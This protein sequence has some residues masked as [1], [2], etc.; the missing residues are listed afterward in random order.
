MGLTWNWGLWA[1]NKGTHAR[2]CGCIICELFSFVLIYQTWHWCHVSGTLFQHPW[3]YVEFWMESSVDGT[4]WSILWRWSNG[5][6]VSSSGSGAGLSTSTTECD[7]ES[8]PPL[9]GSISYQP[10]PTA[11]SIP[12][13]STIVSAYVS[14]IPI[15]TTNTNATGTIHRHL[16]PLQPINL[17]L[18]RPSILM[19]CSNR[20]ESPLSWW[21]I[22]LT[23]WTCP[24]INPLQRHRRPMRTTTISRM[25]PLRH[26]TSLAW[27]VL[28]LT[29]LPF[30]QSLSR[31]S[32]TL[33]HHDKLNYGSWNALRMDWKIGDLSRPSWATSNL[34][35]ITMFFEPRPI[36]GAFITTFPQCQPPLHP[37]FILFYHILNIPM[38]T[39]D[40]LSPPSRTTP[41]YCNH[42][43]DAQRSIILKA[44]LYRPTGHHGA[45]LLRP[46]RQEHRHEWPQHTLWLRHPPSILLE[47]HNMTRRYDWH[48]RVQCITT[49]DG[50]W[51]NAGKKGYCWQCFPIL[52]LFIPIESIHQELFNTDFDKPTFRNRS[53]SL[54]PRVLTPWH[55]KLLAFILTGL[56]PM[57]V[58]WTRPST[59]WYW[60]TSRP[61][62]FDHCGLFP[63]TITDT[64]EWTWSCNV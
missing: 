53:L 36:N 60:S 28:F 43:G 20:I 21:P 13:T 64:S 57:L 27:H 45:Q 40:N 14:F 7:S 31:R 61:T 10:S 55:L 39:S 58:C 29:P 2:S 50:S 34:H 22:C 6:T 24:A 54:A 5:S 25:I 30:I 26:R 19:R 1:C 33:W 56:L 46:H 38:C 32:P 59:C 62:H 17:G 12:P 18:P 42:A 9:T 8:T 3:L 37:P 51:I 52:P 35:K 4:S 15:N 47:I 23:I 48:V 63:F 49:L 44:L 16:R 11:Y 41:T